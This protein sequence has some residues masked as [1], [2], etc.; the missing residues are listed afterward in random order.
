MT[1]PAATAV[2]PGR[3]PLAAGGRERSFAVCRAVT[4]R[5]NSSFPLA[6][7][8]LPPAK[9][10]AMDALYAFMRITDD[11]ADEPAPVAAKRANLA[12]WRSGLAASLQGRFTHPVFPALAATVQRYGVPVRFLD[13]VIDGV[14]GDLEPVRFAA[15]AEL[16]PYCYRVASAVGLACVR[17]WGLRSGA[18]FEQTLAPAEAAGI[19]FQLTNI[20]RDLAEDAANGRVYLP[21]DELARFGCEPGT[22]N[23]RSGAFRE[24]MRFQA[25]RAWEYYRRA[26]P[27]EA[28]LTPEGRAIF[29][30][31]C[32][33]YR[34]LLTE[35][36]RRDY[37]V[38]SGRVR[39]PKW[40][41][42]AILLGGWT[43]RL[44]T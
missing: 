24:M 21:L 1:G 15:F 25:A 20:L 35:I 19:A 22:W 28:L 7:R 29:R 4:A 2:H 26:E 39:V 8:L 31:M 14:E 23:A 41:K 5:A 18:T 27:L 12:A 17:V 43:T 40:R 30:V 13:D 6:F 33:T 3:A 32:G 36:E 38:L 34:G 11:L 44:V 16:Y 9:R 10:R 37:D 42:A